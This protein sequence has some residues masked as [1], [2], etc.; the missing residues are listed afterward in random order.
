MKRFSLFLALLATTMSTAMAEYVVGPGDV[1]QI[2]VWQHADLDRQ[3]QVRQDGVITFPPLGDVSAHGLSTEELG[4]QLSE[5]LIAFTRRTTQVTVSVAQFNSRYVILNGYVGQTGRF[6][7]E[8]IPSLVRVIGLAGGA[9]P[10]ALLSDVQIV[11][12]VGE[13]DETLHV[14]LGAYLRGESLIDPPKLQPGDVIIVPGATSGPGAPELGAATPGEATISVLGGVN[15]PGTYQVEREF[16]L[17]EV[18]GLAGG[19]T[20]DADLRKIQVLSREPDGS[21]FVATLD[22]EEIFRAGEPV[23]FPIR[24]GDA[25]LIERRRRGLLGEIVFTTLTLSRNI[26]DLLLIF[27]ILGNDTGGN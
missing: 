7:F 13:R 1:L 19:L 8:E 25:L 16:A 12:Q 2:T 4:Q 18:L 21:E 24:P 11:R 9:Q 17:P 23:R 5:E 20:Q 14:D 6:V 22:L 27:E 10:G 3:V 26:L 15:R